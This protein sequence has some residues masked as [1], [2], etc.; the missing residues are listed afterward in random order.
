MLM[1]RIFLSTLLRRT[2][3]LEAHLDPWVS[4]LNLQISLFT[5]LAD[6]THNASQQLGD[7]TVD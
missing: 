1:I 3:L 2:T 4:P 5:G 6:I 7:I